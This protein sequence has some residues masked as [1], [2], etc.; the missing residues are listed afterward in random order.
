MSR[1]NFTKEQ[2]FS[3]YANYKKY[4]HKKNEFYIYSRYLSYPGEEQLVFDYEG[5]AKYLYFLSD[6]EIQFFIDTY[7]ADPDSKMHLYKICVPEDLDK[8]PFEEEQKKLTEEEQKK[9][10]ERLSKFV[11]K[12]L[13]EDL[14]FVRRYPE[15]YGQL[16]DQAIDQLYEQIEENAVDDLQNIDIETIAQ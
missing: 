2:R 7:F 1:S 10:T 6:E 5:L 9:I 3:F 13:K 12:E 4:V 8:L 15:L 16:Y 14:F 11:T